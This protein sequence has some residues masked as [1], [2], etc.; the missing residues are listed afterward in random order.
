M[1]SL[2]KTHYNALLEYFYFQDIN[3]DYQIAFYKTFYHKLHA[4]FPKKNTQQSNSDYH[5]TT[6]SEMYIWQPQKMNHKLMFLTHIKI[7]YVSFTCFWLKP[8]SFSVLY[9]LYEHVVTDWSSE[10]NL[11]LREKIL[12]LLSFY[13]QFD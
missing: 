7:I 10:G 4:Y 13:L 5:I 3:V 12:A 8:W 6:I 11:Y 2:S 1:V 9:Y